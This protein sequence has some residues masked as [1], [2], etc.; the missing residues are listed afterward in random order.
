MTVVAVVCPRR[1]HTSTAPLLP[2]LSPRLL[3]LQCDAVTTV[4]V[5]V[6]APMPARTVT[7]C[8]GVI[9]TVCCHNTPY[10]RNT[11]R[12]LLLVATVVTQNRAVPRANLM[13]FALA[14]WWTPSDKCWCVDGYRVAVLMC[15]C[16]PASWQLL[17]SEMWWSFVSFA[18]S[19]HF[20]PI[21]LAIKVHREYH[22][23][24]GASR[25]SYLFVCLLPSRVL[26][27]SAQLI[28]A[29]HV[30]VTDVPHVTP[31]PTM[32]Q[33][34]HLLSTYSLVRTAW[35][36]WSIATKMAFVVFAKPLNCSQSSSVLVLLLC[37]ICLDVFSRCSR[38]SST[39]SSWWSIALN[40]RRILVGFKP[41][42]KYIIG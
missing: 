34:N 3:L 38:F 37:V 28:T 1:H 11:Q 6:T 15:C 22:G 36:L 30:M 26:S 39:N 5:V 32:S 13:R 42:I 2:W 18:H 17:C 33:I 29:M 31:Q 10:C 21:A 9:T 20:A 16:C 7:C 23:I 25:C 4:T 24:C 12:F 40:A 35:F 27:S 8:H 14:V 19:L 41:C